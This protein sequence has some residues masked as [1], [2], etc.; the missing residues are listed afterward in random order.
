MHG[1]TTQQPKKMKVKKHKTYLW[2]KHVQRQM[3]NLQKQQQAIC[4]P[5][6]LQQAITV[7]LKRR[8]QVSLLEHDQPTDM[9]EERKRGNM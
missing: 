2:A 4:I 6:A 8:D 7:S 1:Q 3:V 5:C 9:D